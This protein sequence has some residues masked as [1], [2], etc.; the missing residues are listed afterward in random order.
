MEDLE[1]LKKRQRVGKVDERTM[2][3]VKRA[4]EADSTGLKAQADQGTADVSSDDSELQ[5][6]VLGSIAVDWRAKR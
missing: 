5:G 6:D 4:R 1:S 2:S 3:L